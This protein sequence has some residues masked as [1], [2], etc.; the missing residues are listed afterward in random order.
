MKTKRS[1][2]RVSNA[3][4][5]VVVVDLS[6]DTEESGIIDTSPPTGAAK[7]LA[8]P[9]LPTPTDPLEAG[10]VSIGYT[11]LLVHTQFLTST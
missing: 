3:G 2:D 9:S 5:V 4:S 6:G 10:L 1:P 11:V 8:S 7:A